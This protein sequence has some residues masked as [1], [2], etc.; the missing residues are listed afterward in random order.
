MVVVVLYHRVR[1]KDQEDILK[2]L[3]NVIRENNIKAKEEYN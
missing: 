2:N 1:R 3:I